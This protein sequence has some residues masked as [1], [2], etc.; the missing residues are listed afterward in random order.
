MSLVSK[1]CTPSFT[2]CDC[3]CSI[4]GEN[5]SSWAWQDFGIFATVDSAP[6]VRRRRH[7][8]PIPDG[9]CQLNKRL[10]EYD[11]GAPILQS[12]PAKRAKQSQQNNNDNHTC[13]LPRSCS[14]TVSLSE[15]ENKGSGRSIIIVGQRVGGSPVCAMRGGG[16]DG[17]SMHG[18]DINRASINQQISAFLL[19]EADPIRLEEE[20]VCPHPPTNDVLSLIAS[21]PFD[22][23]R[24][25]S[26]YKQSKQSIGTAIIQRETVKPLPIMPQNEFIKGTSQR[27]LNATIHRD[28]ST[29]LLNEAAKIPLEEQEEV[30]LQNNY[31]TTNN[32]NEHDVLPIQN[33]TINQTESQKQN[34]TFNTNNNLPVPTQYSTNNNPNKYEVSIR[35]LSTA[36]FGIMHDDSVSFLGYK[37]KAEAV[38]N[39]YQTMQEGDVIVAVNGTKTTGLS[40]KTVRGMLQSDATPTFWHLTLVNRDWYDTQNAPKSLADAQKNYDRAY[41]LSMSVQQHQHNLNHSLPRYEM[42]RRLYPHYE[43]RLEVTTQH[44]RVAEKLRTKSWL[45]LQRLKKLEKQKET[46][47]LAAALRA[48]EAKEVAEAKKVAETKKEA[49]KKADA[50]KK[51]IPTAT[52]S[53]AKR[54]SHADVSKLPVAFGFRL[55]DKASKIAATTAA[56]KWRVEG[57]KASNSIFIGKN[58]PSSKG[59]PESR[60]NAAKITTPR[61]S[62]ILLSTEPMSSK[63]PGWTKQTF[64]RT[65]GNTAGSK[66]TYFYSPH[67]QIKFRAMKGVDTFIR[68]LAEPDVDGDE[69][70]AIEL[71]KKRGHKK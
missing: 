52:A 35:N 41:K 59:T 27:K 50:K 64:K 14:S 34:G 3:S 44:F 24:M 21:T 20:S 36:N 9:T 19:G 53:D 51:M 55:G 49:M 54:I 38:T 46:E 45:K 48:V 71:Y 61:S 43:E 29:F 63:Y 40:G 42:Q 6:P 68:I 5:A 58:T 37:K 2:N 12:K 57:K 1:L 62:A 17:K 66:D 22:A 32:S 31:I 67:Q 18:I 13:L 10:H 16:T 33:G 15:E 26:C 8:Q 4:A 70:K 60:H 56:T 25:K 65:S 28:I 23:D 11:S 39:P 30:P 47:M 7:F 69:S